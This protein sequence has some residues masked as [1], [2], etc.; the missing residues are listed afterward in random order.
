MSNEPFKFD[1]NTSRSVAAQE[2]CSMDERLGVQV[3]QN[4]DGSQDVFHRVQS[5][6]EAILHYNSYLL[7]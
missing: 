6:K 1:L 2:A 3:V 7:R 4:E 5:S